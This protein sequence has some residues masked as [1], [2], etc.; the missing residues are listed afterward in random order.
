MN[1][2]LS[3]TARDSRGAKTAITATRHWPMIEKFTAINKL[4]MPQNAEQKLHFAICNP[5]EQLTKN[6]QNSRLK[7]GTSYAVYS[8]WSSTQH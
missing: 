8:T 4:I 1:F 5:Q 6:K 2:G 7:V 3:R